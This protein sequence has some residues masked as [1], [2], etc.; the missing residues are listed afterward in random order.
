M[1]PNNFN[2]CEEDQLIFFP[3]LSIEMLFGSV[4]SY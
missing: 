4:L 1:L 3:G 2:L